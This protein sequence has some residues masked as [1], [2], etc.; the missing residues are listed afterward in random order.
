MT[1]INYN[2]QVIGV[3]LNIDKIGDILIPE[4]SPTKAES[5]YL[6]ENYA[7]VDFIYINSDNIKIDMG[8]LKPKKI[9]SN[10]VSSVGDIELEKQDKFI[11]NKDSVGEYL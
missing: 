3:Y 2:N 4:I 8:V 11:L 6:A 5:K 9:I 7:N 1:A 10:E